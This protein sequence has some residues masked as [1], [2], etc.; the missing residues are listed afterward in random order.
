M[1]WCTAQRKMLLFRA[2]TIERKTFWPSGDF[3][4][5]YFRDAF[6]RHWVFVMKTLEDER[7]GVISIL[8]VR[9]IPT[10]RVYRLYDT[11]H[12]KGEG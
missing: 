1:G 11:K 2:K 3:L 8:R 12:S 4:V 6:Q 9:A 5:R 7:Y 10:Y